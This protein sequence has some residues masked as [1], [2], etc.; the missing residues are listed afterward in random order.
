MAPL[1][2]STLVIAWFAKLIAPVAS[3]API[4]VAVRV[5]P[6]KLKSLSSDKTPFVPANTILPEVKPSAVRVCALK[7]YAPISI[8]ALLFAAPV[9][10]IEISWA[11]L[12]VKVPADTF[13]VLPLPTVTFV[14]SIAPLLISTLVIAWFAKLIAPA[15]SKAPILVAVKVS[16]LKLRSLSSDNTPLVPA[17]TI[18]PDVKL[19][20]NKFWALKLLS[21]ISTFVPT[22]FTIAAFWAA[23]VVSVP[24]ET[25]NVFPL[26]TVTFVPSIAP[27]LISTFVIAWFAKLIAPSAS[28]APILVDVTVVNVAAAGVVPPMTVLSTVPPVI[29]KSSAKYAFAIAVPCHTA[30]DNTLVDGLYLRSSTFIPVLPLVELTRVTYKLLFAS[31]ASVIATFVELVA[32]SI[33]PDTALTDFHSTFPSPSA[34]VNT[35]PWEGALPLL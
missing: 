12:V 11:T 19:S 1:L 22:P 15:A 27:L 21:P 6:L 14:P 17:N 25:S 31:S 10:K 34:L 9:C 24:A 33:V 23:D 29:V 7:S 2:I 20:A 26:P 5:S 3:K 16:P 18:L 30:P 35:N 32:F 8:L 28:K 4:L 13:K